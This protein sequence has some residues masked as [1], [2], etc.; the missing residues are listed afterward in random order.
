MFQTDFD[1]GLPIGT[2][3]SAANMELNKTWPQLSLN[4]LDS[5]CM[6]NGR[7]STVTHIHS[8]CKGHSEWRC[9]WDREFAAF[10]HL[11][12]VA[13]HSWITN[14]RPSSLGPRQNLAF[15]D[16]PNTCVPSWHNAGNTIKISRKSCWYQKPPS[17]PRP[18]SWRNTESCLVSLKLRHFPIS[19]LFWDFFFSLSEFKSNVM[20]A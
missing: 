16:P 6:F 5:R 4:C 2:A 8:V 9:R 7:R 15:Q 20:L 14:A 19:Y 17:L 11:S 13:F 10:P 3:L 18:T 12:A 1:W